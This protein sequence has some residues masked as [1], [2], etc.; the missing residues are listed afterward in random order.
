MHTYALT[1]IGVPILKI[2]F[3]N[4]GLQ[5]FARTQLLVP[6]KSLWAYLLLAF[7]GTLNWIPN[8]CGQAFLCSTFTITLNTVPDHIFRTN[9]GYAQTSAFA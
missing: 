6:V 2:I 1:I 9:L 8:K 3:T 4:F 7:T 5:A